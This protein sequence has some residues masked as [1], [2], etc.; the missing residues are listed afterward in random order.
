MEK[1]M[2]DLLTAYALV[3]ATVR[4]RELDDERDRILAM[5]PALNGAGHE[6]EAAPVT[7][8]EPTLE[9]QPFVIPVGRETKTKSGT[10]APMS[11]ARRKAI[12]KRMR[13]YWREKR[14]A[15]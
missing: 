12:S 13:S 9:H 8:E 11:L 7:T 14:Q 2:K 10:R 6:I 4:M 3:G 1:V 15:K 5:F